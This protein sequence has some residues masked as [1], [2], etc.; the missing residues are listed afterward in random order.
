MGHRSRRRNRFKEKKEF[1]PRF[2]LGTLFLI[3]VVLIFVSY[4]YKEMF[5]PARQFVNNTITPMQSGI[6]TVGKY[7]SDKFRIFSDIKELQKENDKLKAQI[8]ELKNENMILTQEKYELNWYRELYDLD[9]KYSEYPKV[10]AT[11]ISREPNSYCNVFIIDKGTDN[12]IAK[13]M[14]VI[15]GSGLVGIVTDVGKNWAKV[16]SVIDDDTSISGMF[17]KTSDTCIVSGN[18]ELLDKGYIN[19]SM[20]NLKAEVYDNYEVVTSYISD[21]YLPGILIGYVSNI[22]I[23]AGQMSKE[24]Y[25]TPVVDFQ[26]LEAVL[27]ITRLRDQLDNLD[28]VISHDN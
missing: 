24:A 25:L 5:T 27:V 18:L 4:R 6:K 7:I 13:D 16:R 28:E 1:N 3:C 23:D 8:D 9:A 26:H 15:A 12:G 20:I 19:V 11:I 17:L 22:G 21:K 2:I 10:A 14:N